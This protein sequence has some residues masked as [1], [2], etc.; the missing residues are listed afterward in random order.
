MLRLGVHSNV[1]WPPYVCRVSRTRFALVER[2][3]SILTSS[4]DSTCIIWDVEMGVTTV[5]AWSAGRLFLALVLDIG[6]AAAIS[7]GD[8]Q[9]LGRSIRVA[10]G[11]VD[12]LGSIR[13]HVVVIACGS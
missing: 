10:P 2:Q 7:G 12:M 3:E 6:H 9:E 8:V 11:I 13:G 4:G 1:S 5:R